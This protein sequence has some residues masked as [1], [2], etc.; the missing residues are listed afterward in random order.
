MWGFSTKFPPSELR[1]P[2]SVEPEEPKD[3]RRA[4]LSKSTEQ[5]SYELTETD[6][7]SLGSN[8]SLHQVFCGYII[9][10]SVVFLWGSW[11]WERVS[12]WFLLL[13]LGS[14][15]SVSLPGPTSMW[16]FLFYVITFCFICLYICC[17]VLLLILRSL[18]FSNK[19]KKRM[20]LEE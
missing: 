3:T 16:W 15:P 13:L 11:V 20:D 19:E 5:S 9:A 18:F 10:F 12:L 14:F 8:T 2:L 7:A 17:C 4:N 6:A 1:E